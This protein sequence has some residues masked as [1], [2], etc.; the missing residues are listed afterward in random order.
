MTRFFNLIKSLR[1]FPYLII[2]LTAKKELKELLIYER[3][4]WLML[5]R[6]HK[7]GIR[8]FMMLLVAFPE[9]RSLFIFRTE[10]N[11]LNLF[12]KGQTNLYFHM[13]TDEIGKGLIIWHG[14]STVL[15]AKKIGENF[16]IWQNVTIGKKTTKDI[17]DRPTIGSNVMVCTGAVVIGDITIGDN[18][19]IGANTTVTKNIP[20]SATAVGVAATIK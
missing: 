10:K 12:A 13:K 18:A 19:I 11:W 5:N 1:F 8:G 7:H 17:D 6:F 3:D 9:Y 4:R 15:N 20:A 16:Q 14:Y 2:F